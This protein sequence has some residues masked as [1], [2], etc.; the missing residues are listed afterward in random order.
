MSEV[1]APLDATAR[2]PIAARDTRCAARVA[3]W[4]AH[5]GVT[6]NAIS[7]ASVVFSALGGAA[8]LATRWTPPPIDLALFLLAVAGIQGRLLCNLFDGMVAV[9]GGKAGK[10][11]EVF[12]D[13]PDRLADPILLIAAGYAAGGAWGIALG[14][15]AG[16]LALMTAYVRVLGRSLGTGIY[17]IGPMAKQHR[18]ATLTAACILAAGGT[19]FGVERGIFIA[20]LTIICLGAS[21]TVVRRTRRVIRDLETQ[22]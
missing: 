9:E 7:V 2:R 3:A 14:W 21:V 12:N 16:S 11:G 10:A 19:F 8:L 18:M 6:P 17:F 22:R 4:L 15:L 20:A 5:V 1:P 13:F